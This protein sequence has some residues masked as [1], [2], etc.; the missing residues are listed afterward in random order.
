MTTAKEKLD[1]KYMKLAL[2]EA[3]KGEF[4]TWPNPWVGAVIVNKGKVVGRGWHRGAGLPHAEAEAL[5]EAGKKAKGGTAYVT[6]EPCNHY[7]RTPPCAAALV[8]AGIK[9]V[10]AAVPDDHPKAQGG[11]KYLRSHGVQVGPFVLR[12]E[13]EALNRYFF[14]SVKSGRP[15]FTLKAAA[16]LD[17]RTATSKGESQWIT[18]AEARADSRVL[19]GQCDAVLVG[20]GTVAKDQPSLMPRLQDRNG[21]VPWRL[22]LDP[23]GQLKGNE[24]VFCD[25][26]ASRTI[27]FAGAGSFQHAVESAR[28]GGHAQ[29][30]SLHAGGLSGAVLSALEWMR[31]HDLRRVMVE[32]GAATLG[33]FLKL[34]LADELVLYL[35]PR[36]EGSGKGLPI[37]MSNEERRLKEWP[38]LLL[39]DMR[40]VGNDIRI[41]GFFSKD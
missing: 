38:G 1:E 33:A 31:A 16:S 35:A 26:D 14:F 32:G 12:A 23:R 18:S 41:H 20:A 17:G 34:G 7:G 10:V 37:F 24:S 22:V 4:Q 13:A 2:A 30:Q 36:L 27:W 6:L 11:L 19:R 8:E 28:H 40:I 5:R 39:S 29:I 25:A 15:W 3:K 9:R 21:F